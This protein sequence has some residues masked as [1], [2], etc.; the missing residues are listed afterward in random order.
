[1]S[2][3]E[4][5]EMPES[6]GFDEEP[7]VLEPLPAEI[8]VEDDSSDRLD[9]LE[10]RLDELENRVLPMEPEILPFVFPAA[11]GS[12]NTWQE[13]CV[14]SGTNTTFTNGVRLCNSSSDSAAMLTLGAGQVFL[15]QVKTGL[16]HKYIQISGSGSGTQVWIKFNS[17]ADGSLSAVAAYKYD[18]YSDSAMTALIVSNVVVHGSYGR[19][20]S[21][22]TLVKAADGSTATL[23]YE[24]ATPYLDD[25]QEIR[26]FDTCAS[27]NGGAPGTFAIVGNDSQLSY[28]PAL[29]ITAASE[30]NLGTLTWAGAVAPSGT[31]NKKY[32][33]SR[34]GNCITVLVKIDASVAGT[35]NTSVTFSLP[36]VANGGD[37]PDPAT[38]AS[39][40]NSTHITVGPGMLGSTGTPASTGGGM[41]LFVDGSAVFKIQI[42]DAAVGAMYAWGQLSY[43]V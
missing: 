16:E 9:E 22:G 37:M 18:A 2:E 32:R 29:V 21:K 1:M 43:M 28:N 3:S 14:G 19:W 13:I 5:A 26:N 42:T 41:Q 40:P 15:L 12:G 8:E 35:A 31:I 10:D 25:V 4:S 30:G 20:G 24:G 33:W 23:K 6:R 11:S 7:D 39:Q 27:D 38:F 34:N 17:G 36:C